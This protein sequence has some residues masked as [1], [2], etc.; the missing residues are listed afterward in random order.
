MIQFSIIICNFLCKKREKRKTPFRYWICPFVFLLFFHWKVALFINWIFGMAS[1]MTWPLISAMCFC[2]RERWKS[3]LIPSVSALKVVGISEWVIRRPSGRPNQSPSLSTGLC[4]P[5]VAPH[6]TEHNVMFTLKPVE[7]DRLVRVR[8]LIT[9]Q[10]AGTGVSRWEIGGWDEGEC[11]GLLL[12][13][14]R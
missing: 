2:A 10:L 9:L 12:H 5:L 14:A 13:G 1:N 4:R 7:V 11:E 8:K 6:S 3:T